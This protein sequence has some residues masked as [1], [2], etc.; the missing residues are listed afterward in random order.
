MSLMSMQLWTLDGLRPPPVVVLAAQTVAAVPCIV[1][2][3][4]PAMG[5]IGFM[6]R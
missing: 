4:F 6:T 3:V 5:A 2:I 1:L